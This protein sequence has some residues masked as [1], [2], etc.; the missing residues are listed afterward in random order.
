MTSVQRLRSSYSVTPKRT[1]TPFY[2]CPPC[3]S[4]RAFSAYVRPM[5]GAKVGLFTHSC[6]K[7]GRKSI[8]NNNFRFNFEPIDNKNAVYHIRQ[9]HAFFFATPPESSTQ[10]GVKRMQKVHLLNIPFSQGRRNAIQEWRD[11]KSLYSMRADCKSARTAAD[12]G[13]LLWLLGSLESFYD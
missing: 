7:K 4:P 5:D 12:G 1:D 8:H 13:F 9:P 10:R 3:L 6:K 11:C 2:I